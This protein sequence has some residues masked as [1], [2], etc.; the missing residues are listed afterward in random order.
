LA[1]TSLSIAAVI[2]AGGWITGARAAMHGTLLAISTVAFLPFVVLAAGLALVFLLGALLVPVHG[3]GHGLEILLVGPA[4]LFGPYY[5]LLFRLRRQPVAVGTLIGA[6]LGAL[7]LWVLIL[8]LVVPRE[9]STAAILVDVRDRIDAY[10]LDRGRLPPPSDDGTLPRTTL[11]LAAGPGE[12]PTGP[13][14][15]AF[16]RPIR[17]RVSGQG[18]WASYTLASLGYDGKPGGDDICI[19]GAPRVARIVD[20]A[21][22]ALGRAFGD[23]RP[24]G[25]IGAQIAALRALRCPSP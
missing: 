7:A 2:A 18:L 20:K 13:I 3:D 15:D 5:R 12:D 9:V 19:E 10:R 1:V 4:R 21:L 8:V 24:R 25:S 23:R 16:G 17:Y 6:S 11:G 22:D 14:A